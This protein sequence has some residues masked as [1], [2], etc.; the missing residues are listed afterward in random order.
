MRA[1]RIA[2]RE[3]LGEGERQAG[4]QGGREA[5]RQGGGGCRRVNKAREGLRCGVWGDGGR[6]REACR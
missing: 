1:G 2:E 3:G 5:G 4:R 6:L